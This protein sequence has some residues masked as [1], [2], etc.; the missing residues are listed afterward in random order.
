[1]TEPVEDPKKTASTSRGRFCLLLL[2]ACIAVPALGLGALLLLI[3]ADH[4]RSAQRFPFPNSG[5]LGRVSMYTVVDDAGGLAKHDV[6]V[7]SND[8]G[9]IYWARSL[10]GDPALIEQALENPYVFYELD[11]G[12][13]VMGL[14]ASV[15]TDPDLGER[16]DERM[17]SSCKR[18]SVFPWKT[19]G[20]DDSS[21]ILELSW[22]KRPE[23]CKEP[24]GVAIYELR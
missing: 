3:E 4:S 11:R 14:C 1:M 5:G 13:G 2:V 17:A 22:E 7:V 19:E 20:L 21:R 12:S 8:R 24:R 6:C 10:T 15:V 16:L 18:S 23:S 9:G